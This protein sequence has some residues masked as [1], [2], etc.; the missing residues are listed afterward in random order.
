MHIDRLRAKGISKQRDIAGT[1]QTYA[2]G[3][4]RLS[5]CRQQCQEMTLRTTDPGGFLDMKHSHRHEDLL[6][7]A[8]PESAYRSH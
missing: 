7:G 5:Q 3:D 8:Q 6:R 4:A 1:Q 2:N